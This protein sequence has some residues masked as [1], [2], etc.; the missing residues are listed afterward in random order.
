VSCY[1]ATTDRRHMWTCSGRLTAWL[2]LRLTAWLL[3]RLTGWLLLRLT[4]WL[5]L[6]LTGW[7]LLPVCEP[8]QQAGST[9][10]LI[11]PP[12]PALPLAG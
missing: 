6:R 5:L 12:L 7:W 2:L 3:L 9:H 10:A 1:A 4:A 11:P 8:P